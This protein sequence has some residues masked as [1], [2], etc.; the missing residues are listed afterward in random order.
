M[1]ERHETTNELNVY[2]SYFVR[3]FKDLFATDNP[4][5]IIVRGQLYCESALERLIKNGAKNIDCLEIDRYSYTLKL[6]ICTGFGLIPENLKATLEKLGDYRNKY[7]HRIDFS[8]SE[9]EQRD[10]LNTFKGSLS[11]DSFEK[12]IEKYLAKECT[13]P[14]YIQRTILS[15]WI[16]LELHYLL[17]TEGLGAAKK[18]AE[19]LNT[20]QDFKSGDLEEKFR[21][22]KELID[23]VFHEFIEV[24]EIQRK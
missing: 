17:L 7:V 24:V 8:I 12:A 23:K 13:F 11:D 1:E 5:F 16:F 9:K 4:L 3:C 21:E 18:I 14:E 2:S 19:I 22:V 6:Q 10:L 15:L 20:D